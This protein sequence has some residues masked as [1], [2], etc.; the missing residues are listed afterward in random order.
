MSEM[1]SVTISQH[2]T[3]VRGG[4]ND[5]VKASSSGALWG[6]SSRGSHYALPKPR[7]TNYL[8]FSQQHFMYPM[9]ILTSS[10]IEICE[11]AINQAV[12]N[13][14]SPCFMI[15]FSL[16]LHSFSLPASPCQQ[17]PKV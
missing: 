9:K 4:L 17:M 11:K 1:L 15:D 10:A 6:W 2:P 14:L 16:T 7:N 12:H 13:Q 3:G 5:E 8:Y